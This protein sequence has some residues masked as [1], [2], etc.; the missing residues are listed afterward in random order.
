MPA[1]SPKRRVVFHSFI[2]SLIQLHSLQPLFN[3]HPNGHRFTTIKVPEMHAYTVFVAAHQSI[4]AHRF[5]TPY[6]WKKRCFFLFLVTS[7]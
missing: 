6:R 4:M 7:A 5:I 3:E 2:Q 1:F